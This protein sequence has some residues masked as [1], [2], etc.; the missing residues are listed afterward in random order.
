MLEHA[1]QLRSLLLTAV[2]TG[3]RASELRG[4]TWDAV[5]L[6]RKVLTCA[7][8]PRSLEHNRLTEIGCGQA[9]DPARSDRGQYVARMEARVSALHRQR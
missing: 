7:A 4:L 8:A 9:G 1:G 6:E 5:D 3:L 2:F